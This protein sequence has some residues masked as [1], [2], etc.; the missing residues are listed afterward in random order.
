M[1]TDVS[2]QAIRE[3]LQHQVHIDAVCVGPGVLGRQRARVIKWGQD[4]SAWRQSRMDAWE[5]IRFKDIMVESK[6]W[7]AMSKTVC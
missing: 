7:K 1:Q 5:R 6:E 2:L 4:S 3:A